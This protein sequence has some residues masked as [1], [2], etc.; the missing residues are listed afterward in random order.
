MGRYEFE[1]ARMRD[2]ERFEKGEEMPK[3]PLIFQALLIIVIGCCIALP[4]LEVLVIL[5][6]EGVI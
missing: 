3:P 1:K 5:K 6:M 4:V 2:T